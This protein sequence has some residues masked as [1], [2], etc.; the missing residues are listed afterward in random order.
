MANNALEDHS[1]EAHGDVTD[2]AT[3]AVLAMAQA[4]LSGFI[5]SVISSDLSLC[6]SADSV[7]VLE[8][9]SGMFDCTQCSGYSSA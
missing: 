5:P 4:I 3:K 8:L 1:M 2:A 6:H 9:C 7:H